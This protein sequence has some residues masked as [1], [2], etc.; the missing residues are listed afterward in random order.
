VDKNANMG[1]I[2]D[3]KMELRKVNSLKIN[4]TTYNGDAFRNL[5]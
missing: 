1:I 3:I 5:E 4:Y 2:Q